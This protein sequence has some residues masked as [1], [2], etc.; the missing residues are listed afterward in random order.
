MTAASSSASHPKSASKNSSHASRK[1][2][3]RFGTFKGVYVPSLLTILGVIMY[4][5]S[6]WVVG[7]V[8]LAETLIIVTLSS[9]ITFLTAL[10]ISA[11]ATNMRVGGGGAYYM[12]SRSLGLEAGAAIGLPLFLAQALVISFYIAGFAESVN[13]LFPFLPLRVVGVLTLLALAAVA[14]A[15]ADLALKAQFFILAVIALSLVSF[16]SG[17]PP[18]E[19]FGPA[20][21]VPFRAPFWVVFAVFFPAVTGIEAGI[22][23]SGDLKNPARAL[24]AG[25]I[26]AVLTGY[27]VYVAIPV[28]LA[29]WVP[30][31]HLLTDTLVM[32]KVAWWGGAIILGVWAAT[33]SSALSSLLGAPRTL[34]ALARDGI[35]PRIL[36]RGAGPAGE[37]R[38]ATG[39]AF[40][41]ALIGVL[42]G[43][44]NA[45]APILSMFFLTSYGVL[46][47]AAGFEGLIDSPSWR[48]RFRVPWWLSLLGAFGCVFAMLMIDP[49]ATFVAIFLTGLVYYLTQR[50]EMKAHWGDMRYGLLMLLARYAIYRL[51]ESK[52]SE[53]SWRPNILAL[54]GSPTTRWHLIELADAITHGHGFLSV[55]TLIPSSAPAAGRLETLQASIRDYLKKRNVPALVEVKAVDDLMTG[56]QTL[57]RYYGIGPL[58]PNTVLLGATEKDERFLGFAALLMMAYNRKRNLV[59]VR[60]TDSPLQNAGKRRIDVWWGLQRQNA[61]LM[62]ALAHML[63]TSVEWRDATIRLRTLVPSREKQRDALSRLTSFLVEARIQAE[64]EVLVCDIEDLF[65]SIR[66]TSREADLVFVGLRPPSDGESP[67]DFSRY[68][69]DLLDK[70]RGFPPTALVLAAENISFTRIFE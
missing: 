44:L 62:L 60:E 53:K 43:D 27:A 14:Y 29:A 17:G 20:E 70:T 59:V 15:S 34:Q 57:I 56:A 24:P 47:L 8:G 32:R 50:R 55:V 54:S 21:E 48:P 25:T 58:V 69:A 49:G 45:I 37:P 19:G 68:Y 40:S 65:S 30:E 9:S 18:P 39:V 61:G 3:R 52:A 38:I 2:T 51:G 63:Q 5:R 33:L 6:G 42:L 46:N 26:A 13:A 22:A 28:T 16:F 7:N 10:S 66:E 31:E 12:I 64:A 23:L 36:G 1:Q 67:E 4:L 11:I 35:V 41:V